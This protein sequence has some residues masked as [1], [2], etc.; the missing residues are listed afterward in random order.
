MARAREESELE[1]IEDALVD[2]DVPYQRGTAQAALRHRDF[3]ILYFGTF[4]SNIGTWMQNVVLGAFAVKLTGSAATWA[5]CSS[6]NSAR[7]CSCRRWAACS[8]TSSTGGASSSVRSS[9]SSYS[10]SRWP[11]SRAAD[12]PSET[13]IVVAVFAVGIANAL[14]AP[15]LSAILPTLVPRE[16]M[17]GAVALASVQMNLSRVIGP[18]IGGFLYVKFDAAPVFAINAVT[19]LFA[20]VGLVWARYPRRV[21]ARVAERGLARLLSGMRIARADRLL[22]YVLI[23]LFTFSFFSLAFV[24]LMPKIA[25]TNLG[26]DPRSNAY[27]LLYASFGSG[28][29]RR[30][31][32]CRH[33]LRDRPQDHLAASRVRGVRGRARGLR[34]TAQPRVGVSDRRIA[35]LRVLRRDH[36]AV[37]PAAGEARRPRAR[38]GDGVVDHGLRR[39]CPARRARRRLALAAGHD[40]LGG[41]RRRRGLGARARNVVECRRRSTSAE[42]PTSDVRRARGGRRRRCGR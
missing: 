30:R 13:L 34:C 19:Y 42:P 28:R 3:R 38:P 20:V 37:D 17:P 24:G 21:D 32:Q 41:H 27:A 40:D 39:D 4:S 2:G 23:T 15:G 26:L 36:L 5:S 9:P 8:P 14:G 29:S 16:D 33:R 22:S 35:R 7:C 1:Q 18:I 10:R 31:G 12:H 11:R 25:S 6:R